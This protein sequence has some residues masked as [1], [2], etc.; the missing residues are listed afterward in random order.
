MKKAIVVIP[1]YNESE[2]IRSVISLLKKE[3]KGIRAIGY[4]LHILVADDQSPDGTSD[5]VKSLQ[6]TDDHIHLITGKKA[7]LGAAYARVFDKLTETDTYDCLVT[8]D[9]DLSHPPRKVKELLQAIHDGSSFAIGSR[10]I[11]G[12]SI[13]GDWPMSRILNTRVANFVARN[14]GGITPGIR[15]LTA[16]FRAIKISSLRKMDYRDNKASG[17][18]FQI[19]LSNQMLKSEEKISE[20]PIDFKDRT[21][22]ES[23][24]QLKDITNFF[25]VA[26]QLN[27]DSPAKQLMRY[28]L[29]GASGVVIN[30]SVLW[31]LRNGGVNSILSTIVALEL[32]ILSNFVGHSLLTFQMTKKNKSYNL[33]NPYLRLAAFHAASALGALIIFLSALSL[34]SVGVHYLVAQ[35][36][37]ILLAAAVNYLLLSRTIWSPFFKYA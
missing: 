28:G 26:W 34:E 33:K 14:L 10:Y 2:N 20:I 29:V 36:N 17:Y 18:S 5:I 23:K 30:L 19:N 37:G 35:S 25:R 7:G 31:Y 6:K 13:P 8:M 1:T 11:T 27:G 9:A 24:I 32:S 16:G 3:E 12:G 22:G 21:H 4:D 15:D